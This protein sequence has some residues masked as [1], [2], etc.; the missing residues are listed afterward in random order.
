MLEAAELLGIDIDIHVANQNEQTP[1]PDNSEQPLEPEGLVM[2]EELVAGEDVKEE[3]VADDVIKEEDDGT[4]QCK[5]C[6]YKTTRKGNKSNMHRHVKMVHSSNSLPVYKC[7]LPGCIFRTKQKTRMKYHN[8]G[9][10][11]GVRF[12]CGFCQYQTHYRENLLKHIEARHAAGEEAFA[13]QACDLC[14]FKGLDLADL[15]SH[16]KIKHERPINKQS[17]KKRGVLISNQSRIDI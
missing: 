12:N 17:I 4:F 11:K 3:G 6:D 14:N 5:I 8:E 7:P 16:T 15:K 2:K 9:K 13:W 10:H 1:S